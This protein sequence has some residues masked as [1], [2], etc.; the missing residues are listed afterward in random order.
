LSETKS[1]LQP[2]AESCPTQLNA[3]SFWF[4]NRWSG[5]QPENEIE[6]GQHPLRT[7]VKL[8]RIAAIMLTQMVSLR[9]RL[10]VCSS[11]YKFQ[12]CVIERGELDRKCYE[13]L[14]ALPN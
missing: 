1:S 5:R 10:L 3:P 7:Q 8:R 11:P 2:E 14:C 9:T 4:G 6:T 12:N 13:V